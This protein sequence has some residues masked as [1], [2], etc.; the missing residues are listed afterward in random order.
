[1]GWK[2]V[3]SFAESFFTQKGLDLIQPFKVQWYNKRVDY[4]YHLPDWQRENTLGILIGNSK[5]LW[6]CLMEYYSQQEPH[7]V[8][9]E[10]N[11]VDRYCEK[12]MI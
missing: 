8:E 5:S 7:L 3:S 11:P 2:G 10:L 9:R 1:M 6:P 4:R 12:G